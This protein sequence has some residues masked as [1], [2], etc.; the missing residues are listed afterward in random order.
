[1]T[2]LSIS[3]PVRITARRR[4]GLAKRCFD[5]VVS[6]IAI[7]VLLPLLAVIALAI[8]LD[9]PGPVLFIQTRIGHNGRPFRIKKFRTMVNGAD[10]MG[11]NLSPTTDARITRVGKVLR[12]WYFDEF[13]QLWNVLVGD[14]SL[15]GP[16]PETPEFVTHYTPE[17]R[18]V[19]E[20]RPGLVGPSTLIS[21]DEETWLAKAEDP[22][23]LYTSTILH[24]RVE[25]DLGYLDQMSLRYDIAVLVRQAWEIVRRS[26]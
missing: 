10:R 18:R 23:A 11:P 5:L 9:S 22:V 21:M 12:H 15:V 24:R 8:K 3:T 13:P 4:H 26:K 25:A 2:E 20:V 16:R 6:G 14:M 19:L 17:Q 1:M 7:V